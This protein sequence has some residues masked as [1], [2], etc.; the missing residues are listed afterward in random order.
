MAHFPPVYSDRES[1]IL[2]AVYENPD[3]SFDTFSLTQRL[4]QLTAAV[5]EFEPQ[6]KATVKATEQLI[7]KSLIDSN[8]LKRGQ[9]RR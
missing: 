8:Q 9:C 1:A 2:I 6:F 5:P 4:T 3:L 7:V